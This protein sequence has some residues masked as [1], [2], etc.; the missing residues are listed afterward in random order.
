MRSGYSVMG[1]WRGG[2]MGVQESKLEALHQAD[3]SATHV[4]NFK[5]NHFQFCHP[6]TDTVIS[7]LLLVALC[8][9]YCIV[10]TSLSRHI[11]A[12]IIIPLL[13]PAQG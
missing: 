11:N 4:N 1:A 2:A 5:D 8:L 12:C 3:G 6:L 13:L 7:V 10:I 9:R